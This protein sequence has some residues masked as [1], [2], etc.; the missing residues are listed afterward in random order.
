MPV[1][2]L[3]GD[4]DF[5]EWLRGLVAAFI[6]GGASAVTGGF[7]VSALDPRDYNLQE[8]MPRLLLLMGA[9]FLVNGILSM[10]LFLRQKPVPDHK[11]APLVD[12][13]Q[14]G[15]FDPPSKV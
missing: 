6:S 4:L 8:G 7:T 9:M 15:P 1:S 14:K 5:S 10:M 12:S 13:R 2:I 11:T 3:G